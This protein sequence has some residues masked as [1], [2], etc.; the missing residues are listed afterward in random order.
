MNVDVRC[1]DLTADTWRCEVE[2]TE[3]GSP[4]SRHTVRVS[5]ADVRR[6]APGSTRPEE[7]VERSFCFLLDREAPSMI[8][9]TFDLPDI[10]RYF[11]EYD[12]EIRRST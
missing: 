12:R 7:L 9:R 5:I 6:F 4:V 3:T 1:E 2:L 10:G 8:L 11:P